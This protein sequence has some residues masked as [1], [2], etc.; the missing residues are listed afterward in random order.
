MKIRVTSRF[1]FEA[2]HAVKIGDAW[3]EVHGHT[4]TLEVTVEGPLRRDYVIDFLKLRKIVEGVVRELDHRNLNNLLDNPT[5]ENIAL[6]IAGRI[7]D[8]LPSH[9]KLKRV[10]LWEGD[11]NAVELEF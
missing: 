9:V 1:K 3:E 8:R 7:R 11:E 2:A 5:V 10:I 4:F 6:R